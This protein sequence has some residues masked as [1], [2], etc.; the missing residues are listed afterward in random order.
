VHRVLLLLAVAGPAALLAIAL[1]GWWLARRA[2][3]PVDRM[4]STAGAIGVDR[5]DERVPQPRTEDE[6]A[7]LARTL[8]GMLARIEDG[9]AEQ[10]RL[11]ADASHELRTPLTAMGAELDVSLRMDDLSPAARSVLESAREEVDHLSRLVDDLLLL[12]DDRPVPTAVPVD[13]AALA[14]EVVAAVPARG[15][16]VRVTGGGAVTRGDRARLS[17]A[18]RNLVENAIDFSPPGATVHVEVGPPARIAVSDAGPGIPPE[19]R[20]RVFD[21][22]FRVDPSRTRQTGGAGLGLAIV[23]ET[24]AAHG[25]HVRVEGLDPGSRFVIELDPVGSG[26][27][28][29]E[30]S[31][32]PGMASAPR[33]SP[34]PSVSSTPSRTI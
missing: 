26:A 31:R 27:A 21:R 12:G 23:R 10:R 7:H 18:V 1:G 19:L 33:S 2:L 20:E 22:F 5:L 17:R 34:P 13:L 25:G 29:P 15:V 28:C 11:V 32:S 9:V 8:N 16:D 30:S 3:R 24:V 6:L 14:H 4:A